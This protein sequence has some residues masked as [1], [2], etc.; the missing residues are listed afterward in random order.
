MGA[1]MPV[2]IKYIGPKDVYEDTLYG[3]GLVW[4]KGFTVHE[5]PYDVARKMLKH[6]DCFAST[7]AGW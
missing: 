5:V 6:A 3:T 4:K 1:N 2:K 7:E